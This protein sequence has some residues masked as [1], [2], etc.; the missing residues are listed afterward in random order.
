MLGFAA[1][2]LVVNYISLGLFHMQGVPTQCSGEQ[3]ELNLCAAMLHLVGDT[4]RMVVIL[5][6]GLYITISESKD[7]GKIDAWCAIVVSVFTVGLAVPV[8]YGIVLT[9][10]GMCTS[11]NENGAPLAPTKKKFEKMSGEAG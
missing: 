1:V 10:N 7:S 11:P 2:G 9:A 3:G 5:V 4:I 6:S 8:V